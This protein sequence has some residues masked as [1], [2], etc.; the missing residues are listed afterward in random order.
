MA[1]VLMVKS[2]AHLDKSSV[3]GLQFYEGNMKGA[4]SRNSAKLGNY[5][6]LVKLRQTKITA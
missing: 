1:S 6:M 4:V 5:R 2:H 3:F